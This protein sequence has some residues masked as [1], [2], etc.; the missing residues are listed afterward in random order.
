M[1][2]LRILSLIK[3]ASLYYKAPRSSSPA[4]VSCTGSGPLPLPRLSC[5]AL[6]AK[7]PSGLWKWCSPAAL[8]LS[9]PLLKKPVSLY[10]PLSCRNPDKRR[11][12][13]FTA[14]SPVKARPL[15]TVRSLGLFFFRVSGRADILFRHPLPGLLIK[16]FH[17]AVQV[18]VYA[19]MAPFPA[20]SPKSFIKNALVY[21]CVFIKQ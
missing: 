7:K 4:P 13:Q 5:Q 17:C 12:I 14:D 19:L 2:L 3:P 8:S 1:P 16:D 21:P 9:A 6:P 10:Y 15:K 20:E 11:G 18:P